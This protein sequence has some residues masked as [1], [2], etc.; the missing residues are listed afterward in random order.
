MWKLSA[1]ALAAAVR[2]G[3]V[4]ALDVMDAHLDRIAAVNP[5]INAVTQLFGDRARAEARRIDRRRAA[6]EELGP[7]AGV[8]F[9]VK[10]CIRVEG[11]PTTFGIR[12][13]ADLTAR[14]D[15]IPVARLRAA[16]AVPIG[17]SNMPSLILSGMHTRSELYGD[18]LNPW[19]AG[20]TPGGTSGGDGAAVATGMAALGLGDDSGGSIRIPASFCGV[21]ALNPTAGRF[22]ADQR[23]LGPDDPGP[24]SQILVTDGPLART[25]ADLRLAFECLAGP[26]PRDPR[27]VPAPLYGPPVDG[28]V[29]VAVVADPGGRGVH[30]T[31]RRAVERAAGALAEAGYDVREVPDV[32]RFDEAYDAFHQLTVAEFTPSWPVVRQLLGEGGDRFIDFAMRRTPQLDAAG[33]IALMGTWMNIRR[34][35]AEFLA[36]YPLLLGPVF[37]E[38]PVEPGLESRDQESRDRVASAMR[39]CS[40]TSFVGA[41]AVAVP[42]GP[43]DGLPTGVQLVG[44]PFREDLCLAAAQ[45]LEDRLGVLSPVEPLL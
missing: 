12:R 6:G 37:T 9:T 26:D 34:S 30:P 43:A 39:L 35:W 20:R 23:M 14:A 13:F 41:P 10:E 45:Q 22:A 29:K 8:P 15:A 28:P 44:R 36:E 5:R 16:G 7:L 3:E 1:G 31:V 40:L 18:T 21:A 11:Y 25:V 32:P 17:H 33:L 24:A 38:P 2:A 4:S 27:A 19:D 42:T